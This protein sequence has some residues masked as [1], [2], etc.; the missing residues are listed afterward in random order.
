MQIY[1]GNLSPKITCYDLGQLLEPA[2]GC[3]SFEF[4]SYQK[5]RKQFYYALT[6]IEPDSLARELISRHN[7]KQIK[8]R[9]IELHAYNDRSIFNERRAFGWGGKH[10]TGKERR[11]V[12]RRLISFNENKETGSENVIPGASA[13]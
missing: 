4:R 1:I 10:W 7:R 8:N 3:P 6:S 12:D 5:G 11:N 2:G 9:T 13:I